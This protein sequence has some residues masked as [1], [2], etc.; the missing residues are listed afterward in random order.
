MVQQAFRVDQ[1]STSNIEFK[2]NSFISSIAADATLASNVHLVLPT[3]VGSSG[4][5]LA[6]DGSGNLSFVSQGVGGPADLVQDNVNSLT[7]TVDSFGVYANN[8]FGADGSNVSV[9]NVTSQ[10]FSIDG[11]TNTFT[12]VNTTDN[13]NKLLVSYG[14]IAQKPSEYTDTN[15]GARID[16]RYRLS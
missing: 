13:V 7:S 10:E 11:S 9:A 4:Q 6:T 15:C 16:D 3:S 8:T 5:V 14:G 12:L 2:S 1:V